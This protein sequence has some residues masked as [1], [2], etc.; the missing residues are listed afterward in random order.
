MNGEISGTV[1]DPAGAAIANAAVNVTNRGTGFR[2]TATTGDSG[3][4]RFNL[5]PL[6]TDDLEVGSTRILT[7][8]AFRHRSECWC[9]G[10]RQPANANCRIDNASGSDGN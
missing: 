10:D 5:L 4:Y 3:L 7:G 6:G 2:Q 9:H 8:K 1:T